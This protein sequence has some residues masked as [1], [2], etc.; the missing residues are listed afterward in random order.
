M[1]AWQWFLAHGDKLLSGATGA[2]LA[3]AAA[4]ALPAG[5]PWIAAVTGVLSVLHTAFF[6]EP[7]PSGASASVGGSIA[8]PQPPKQAGFARLG[9]LIPLA[10][11]ASLAAL[12]AC[13]TL[14]T[15][16]QQAGIAAA[17]DIAAGL[18]IQQ[19]SSDPAVWK[20]RAAQFEA[21]AKALQ[22]VNAAGPT[23]LQAIM[24]DL[25]PYIA[26]LG[27][28]DVLAANALV[29]ALTPIIQQQLGTNPTLATTQAEIALILGDVIS[30]CAAYTGA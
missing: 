9:L 3:L 27:P 7:T 29:A 20:A 30:A 11:I 4:G 22:S 26:K 24:A 1:K 14:P 13:K 8:P 17:V 25:Q 16:S 18:A 23:T 21:A 2:I 10:A 19:G 12:V 5:A 28:A 15:G 6:P